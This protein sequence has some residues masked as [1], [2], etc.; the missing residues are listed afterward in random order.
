MKPSIASR[1]VADG[2]ES[3]AGLCQRR[4]SIYHQPTDAKVLNR[5]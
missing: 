1:S 5:L 4:E 2:A 3:A